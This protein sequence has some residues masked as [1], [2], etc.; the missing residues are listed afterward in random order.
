M[1]RVLSIFAFSLLATVIYADTVE[2]DGIYYDL[3]EKAQ[4][5]KVTEAPDGYTGDIVIPATVEYNGVEYNVVA[6]DNHAFSSVTSEGPT[7]VTLSEGLT[8]IGVGAFNYCK[9]LQSIT[10]PNSVNEILGAAFRRCESM[11]SVTIGNGIKEIEQY[12]FKGC[13]S[14]TT[15]TI[16]DNVEKIQ[17]GAFEECSKLQSLILGSGITFI[18][19]NILKDCT[20]L[21]DVYCY[22]ENV[23]EA[24]VE[25]FNDSYIEYCTLHV[26]QSSLEAYKAADPWKNFKEIV[27]LEDSDPKTTDIKSIKTQSVTDGIYDLNGR[28][29]RQPQKG[30][31]IINGK[32]V[33]KK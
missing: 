18:G 25:A 13:A 8:S 30:V 6:I 22:A 28:S 29:V 11:N 3:V 9:N 5:A 7:S 10:I 20:E 17:I 4:E 23:P 21:N 15:L 14:L 26:P 2:I 1:K 27:P 16:P 24:D 12:L 31:Y 32:K 33:I 19:F